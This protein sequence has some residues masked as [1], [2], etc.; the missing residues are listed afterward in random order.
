MIAGAGLNDRDVVEHV[1]ERR[2]DGDRAADRARRAVRERERRAAPD[3]RGRPQPPPHRPRRR[4]DRLR[5]PA[6]AREPRRPSIRTSRSCPTWSRSTSITGRHAAQFLDQRRGPRPL[7]LQPQQEAGRSADRAGRRSSP[8]A[9]RAAP[10]S[11]RPL[12][13][14]RP[15]TGSPWRG[16]RAAGSPTWSSC[17][18][19][20]PASTISQVKNFLITEAVR[21]EGG[22]LKLP[23]GVKGGGKRFMPR[24]DERAELAPRDIVARAIDHE[25]KRLGLDYVHLDISHRDADFV[26]GHFPNIY[27]KLLGLGI[28]ITREPI[29]VVPAQ[30]YT[31]GGVVVDLRR[32]HRR[33]RP[34]RR[35]RGHPVRAPR[36]QPP[37]LEQPARMPG[38]RRGGGAAH[39]GELGRR[40]PRCPT[41]RAVGRKPGDRQ[42]RGSGDRPDLGRDPPLHVELCRHRPHHQAARAGQA[43]DRHAAA[44]GR[45]IIT[46]H[47]RVTPDLIELRN[48]VEV[49]D[50]I[51]RSRA[52][53]ARK[54]RAALHARFPGDA[55]EAEGH[56]AGAVTDGVASASRSARTA[57]RAC[58]CGPLTRKRSTCSPT[59]PAPEWPTA[60]WSPMLRAGGPRHRDLALSI[61]LHGK[62]RAPA[63]PAEDRPCRG[64]RR[65]RARRRSSP[66]TC[67]C[68]PAAARSADG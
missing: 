1:V 54:P 13:A 36:R 8:P 35:R 58:S 3:P 28:D 14:G 53:A 15:A 10:I 49:A 42:R 60:R 21:G 18:S 29:P 47:F 19:T 26:R 66:R 59:A 2:A 50:L 40:L 57:S 65:G 62:G 22:Q 52:A 56:G 46:R 4:R 64:A 23:P 5:D 34:L 25:I 9:A 61:P 7:C 68:S 63:R 31:C 24:F 41:I 17:S 45:A 39:R 37:R 6:G 11:T 33:A 44:G 30:H 38:V 12:R 67:H 55:A 48:L 20:R 27:E 51:I 43:P 16:G 32:P